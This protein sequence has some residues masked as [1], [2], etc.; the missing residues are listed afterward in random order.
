MAGE[1]VTNLYTLRM[2]ESRV[3]MSG[4]W[5]V[6]ITNTLITEEKQH[7]SWKIVP[8]RLAAK[9]LIR[10]IREMI[11]VN[12]KVILVELWI[13]KIAMSPKINALNLK[14]NAFLIFLHWKW[15]Y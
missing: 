11:R 14:I 2:N 7:T 10:I 5:K 3:W 4:I 9:R 1:C 8:P 6:T 12:Q 15:I 13:S